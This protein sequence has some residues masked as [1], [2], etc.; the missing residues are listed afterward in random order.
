MTHLKLLALQLS[1]IF[2]I[3]YVKFGIRRKLEVPLIWVVLWLGL[4]ALA[5]ISLGW[6]TKF[7]MLPENS[8]VLMIFVFLGG[9]VGSMSS[10]LYYG[11]VAMFDAKYTPALAIGEGLSGVV[12]ASLSILQDAGGETMNFSIGFFFAL[13]GIYYYFMGIQIATGIAFLVSMLAFPYLATRASYLIENST[14]EK[15]NC[16]LQMLTLIQVNFS[17]HY[18]HTKDGMQNNQNWNFILKHLWYVPFRKRNV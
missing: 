4:I 15:V 8:I 17:C 1:N 14:Q 12:A 9:I 2:P 10:V 18:C 6:N 11:L 7:S 5:G 16:N 13:A 3:L